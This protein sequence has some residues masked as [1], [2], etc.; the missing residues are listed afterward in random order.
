MSE[1]PPAK[2]IDP[3]IIEVGKATVEHVNSGAGDDR[4][5]WDKHWNP[6]FVSVEGDGAVFEGRQ[7]VEG[8]HEWWNSAMTV[9]S[10]KAEGPFVG[11]NGFAV[12]YTMDVEAKDGS[13]PRNTM[14]EVANYTVENGKVIREEF[15][16]APHN[17]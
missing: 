7:A 9:H 2:A 10:C 3:R 11:A 14:H 1:A 4:P 15:L 8:K 13:M 12:K 6:K 5:L 16:G 17:C